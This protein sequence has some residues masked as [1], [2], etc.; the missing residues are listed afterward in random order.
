[1]VV[2]HDNVIDSCVVSLIVPLKLIEGAMTINLS[3][4]IKNLGDESLFI[5]IFAHYSF[6]K[7]YLVTISLCKTFSIMKW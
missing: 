6:V 1:M 4:R 3:Q 5:K 7:T 2:K